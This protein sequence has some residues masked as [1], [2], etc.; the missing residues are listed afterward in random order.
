M[1]VAR[2]ISL[3]PEERKTL[4]MQTRGRLLPARVVE[5]ARIVL[6]AADGLQDKEIGAELGDTARDG[7]AVAE[8]VP[9]WR[10]DRVGEGCPTSRPPA[11][12][13]RG[14]R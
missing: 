2:A 6:R 5:R 13:Q 3:N 10:L 1:R 14:H 12:Y 4:E 11:H 7:R 8:S 9:E